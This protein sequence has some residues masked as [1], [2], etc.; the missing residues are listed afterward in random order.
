M[1]NNKGNLN[2]SIGKGSFLQRI[3]NLQI[4]KINTKSF[5]QPYSKLTNHPLPSCS[6]INSI[7]IQLSTL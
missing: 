3:Y 1:N 2:T 5:I 4:T 6:A 7:S